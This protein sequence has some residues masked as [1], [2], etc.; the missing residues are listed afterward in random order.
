MIG[1]FAGGAGLRILDILL[2]VKT[3][4]LITEKQTLSVAIGKFHIDIAALHG[5]IVRSR[6]CQL[7]QVCLPV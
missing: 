3:F 6:L 7:L 2:T 4:L 1:Y 5:A